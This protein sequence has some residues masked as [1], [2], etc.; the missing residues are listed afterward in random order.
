M[1]GI[2]TRW[3]VED[4]A[5]TGFQGRKL[6]QDH[7]HLV[8]HLGR[9]E[10]CSW[11]LG[12]EMLTSLITVAELCVDDSPACACRRCL[13]RH[14]QAVFSVRSIVHDNIVAALVCLRDG[15]FGCICRHCWSSS[16]L[17]WLPA[18]YS[19]LCPRP[20]HT[21]LTAPSSLSWLSSS[22]C[23]GWFVRVE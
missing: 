10:G 14:E 23:E 20:L 11:L 16:A 17:E 22:S 7:R 1:G 5:Y 4:T 18:F 8:D 9:L 6:G 15:V 3:L 13:R 12:S 21:G 2:Y 19:S